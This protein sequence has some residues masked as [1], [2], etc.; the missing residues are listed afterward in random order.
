M[1][2]AID[3]R[4][5][6]TSTGRYVE[7]LLEQLQRLDT[8]NDYVVL[9]RREDYARWQP[10][11]TN[12]TKV[13][14]D[15]PP[16][17]F[18]E[19]LQFA[20]QLQQLR[21]DLVHFTMPQHPLG[22]RGRRV[23]TVHDLTLIHYVNRRHDPLLKSLYKYHLKPV[24]FRSFMRLSLRP[25]THLITPTKYVRDQVQRDFGIP[26]AQISYTYEAA[27][28]LAAV[29]KPVTALQ[30][31]RF[32]LYVGNAY[33]YKNLQRLIDAH[34]QLADKELKLVL[35]GKTD[36]FYRELATYV[37]RQGLKQVVLTGFVPDPELRW[38]YE[39]ALVYAFPSLSEGFGLPAIEAML[40]GVPVVAAR[41]SCLPEVL[42]PA[43]TYFDPEDTADMARVIN[44]VLTDSARQTTLKKAG[45][46]RAE[47]FS[48]QRT[49]E[50]TLAIY[51]E[52]L[53]PV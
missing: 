29:S 13:I 11:A 28:Q 8:A 51:Q 35:V 16:Y 3:A 21:L 50:Q 17:T 22:Y 46:A 45:L 6:Y 33:P 53:K 27:D 31:Q 43:A 20:W 18:R 36:F 38:L 47:Q 26:D 12:F 9:L 32:I 10:T 44:T 48:W 19:Q 15:Y 23:I 24:V 2:I 30:N 37:Q 7:R 49:A 5:I 4:I 39:H 41:A 52:A 42:G 34:T 40:H 1:K 25:A 14:A